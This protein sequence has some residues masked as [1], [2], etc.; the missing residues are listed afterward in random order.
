MSVTPGTTVT[1]ATTHYAL[2]RTIEDMLG[3]SPLGQAAT[4]TSLRPSMHL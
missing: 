4:A 2:L 1:A 3:L